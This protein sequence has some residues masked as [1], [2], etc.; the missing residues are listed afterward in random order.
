MAG[1]AFRFFA[2]L[3]R[4]FFDFLGFAEHGDGKRGSGVGFFDFVLQFG[5][6][7]KKALDVFLNVFLILFESGLDAF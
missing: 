3:V 2:N 7:L 1:L 6:E 4:E 5:G